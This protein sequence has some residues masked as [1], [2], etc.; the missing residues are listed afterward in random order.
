[1]NSSNPR[2]VKSR[3][4][5]RILFKVALLSI[6]GLVCFLILEVGVRVFAPQPASWLS[7]YRQHAKLPMAFQRDAHAAVDTGETQWEVWTDRLGHRCS[8]SPVVRTKPMAVWLGDSFAFG[9][10]VDLE[11][12]WIGQ[13]D[14]LETGAF[15]HLNCGVP[16][17]GPTHYE[18]VLDEALGEVENVSAVFVATYLGNDFHDTVW[19]KDNVMR[20]GV[21]GDDGSWRS[22]MAR[23]L[24]CY[25]MFAR[26]MHSVMGRVTKQQSALVDLRTPAA[27]KV[28]P[29][30]DAIRNYTDAMAR[31]AR[32]CDERSM[33]LVVVVIPTAAMVA[34]TREHGVAT[35]EEAEDER[36]T[37]VRALNILA[38]LGLRVVD[39]TPVL[40]EHDPADL[41][42]RFDGHFTPQGH[43]LVRDLLVRSVP[44][45]QK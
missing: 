40:A 9:H 19:P 15:A 31:I 3:R 26:V 14:A 10:G 20:G 30:K 2:P 4:C 22:W 7:I 8:R 39:A 29:M 36:G 45:L 37:L 38:G 32:T 6:V 34:A 13:L 16:G 12:S 24:H 27:W 43:E 33:P 35:S 23:N 28:S 25:R 21:V 17:Y 5:R 1:M 11:T 18:I 41:Y 42:Y 44:E